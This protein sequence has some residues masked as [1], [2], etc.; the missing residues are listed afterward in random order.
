MF[1]FLVLVGHEE[2]ISKLFPG[3]LSCL[4]KAIGT[5]NS[6]VKAV[7]WD[8]VTVHHPV[9][10][11]HYDL[12]RCKALLFL[13]YLSP[14]PPQKSIEG[15]TIMSIFAMS[16]IFSIKARPVAYDSPLEQLSKVLKPHQPEALEDI[17]V[18]RAQSA[19]TQVMTSAFSLGHL[20]SLALSSQIAFIQVS[21]LDKTQLSVLLLGL[22]SRS[23]YPLMF[24][25]LFDNTI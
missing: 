5:V 24:N 21:G 3:L 6:F 17:W 16:P 18:T 10:Q 1:Q 9:R 22:L 15:I 7:C 14:P 25:W 19:L 4:N 23:W 8:L 11:K 12:S 13:Y 20:D 2:S